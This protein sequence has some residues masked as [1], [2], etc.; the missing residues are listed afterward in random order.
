MCL[1]CGA[2]IPRELGRG[3]S[4][5]CSIVCSDLVTKVRQKAAYAV[6]RLVRTKVIPP[7]S[8]CTCVDCGNNARDYDHRNY[9]AV[10]D[11]APVCRPCNLARGPAEDVVDMVAES[12]GV[13]RRELPS[14]V[15]KLKSDRGLYVRHSGAA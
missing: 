15:A 3:Q 2:A 8:A 11:V 5:Y 7:A 1:I 6:A 4:S 9:A 12:L 14:V 13:S 10:I